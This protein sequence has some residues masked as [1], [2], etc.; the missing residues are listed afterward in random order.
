MVMVGAGA[1]GT[2]ITKLLHLCAKPQ[3]VAV[4]SKGIIG[5]A[6]QDLN[7]AKKMLLEYIDT[8]TEG[9]LA[10]ALNGADIFI[11]VS[12]PGLLTP[13]L[14]ATMAPN[15]IIFALAKAQAYPYLWQFAWR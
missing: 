11:G 1:A 2:A 6:R 15:P 12:Q 4:D 14:V 8:T 10:D 13:E 7:D 9:S 3:I 5:S